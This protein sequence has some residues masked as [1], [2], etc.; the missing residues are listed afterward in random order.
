MNQIESKLQLRKNFRVV[1]GST[2]AI[3]S[4]LTHLFMKL[5]ILIWVHLLVTLKQQQQQQTNKQKQTHDTQ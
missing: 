4:T 2:L 5:N 3:Q 1:E